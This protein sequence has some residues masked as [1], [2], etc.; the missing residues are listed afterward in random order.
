VRI[1]AQA[2]TR[3]GIFGGGTDVDPFR[4]E[5]GGRVL[6]MAI[7]IK[8]TCTLEER[9]GFS[10][11][12]AMGE[13]RELIRLPNRGDDTKFDLIY[14]IIRSY[15]F[16]DFKKGFRFE[17]RFDGVQSAGL[18]SSASAAVSMVGAF[19][20]WLGFKRSCREVAEKAWKAEINLGWISGK[21]D[22]YASAIG[23][24]SFY[25][26]GKDEVKRE[27]VPRE[28]SED[29]KGWC[30]LVYTGKTR[31]SFEVQQTLKEKMENGSANK[32][33]SA[34]SELTLEGKRLL[35]G[36]KFTELGQALDYSWELKKSSNPDSSNERLN[37]IYG[38]ALSAGAIGGK[39]CGA[40]G[41]GH[42]F[43][44]VEPGNK[45]KVIKALQLGEVAFNIDYDG[46]RVS[47]N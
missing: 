46:L 35:Y 25:E 31:H 6:N 7:D 17:D 34:M 14:E 30:L 15:G 2:P 29:F 40:G 1:E 27:E 13:R 12:K 38:K 26:F 10:T 9:G 22:Q 21:Q 18:G 41:E 33:L 44:V 20:E 11:I 16:A 47:R 19:D 24:M 43:F 32:A 3:I 37:Q 36:G 4:S 28:I 45:N 42:F 23:G 8:H 5:L 39:I